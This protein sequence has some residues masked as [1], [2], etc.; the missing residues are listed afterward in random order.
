M[1]D[2]QLKQVYNIHMENSH[3]LVLSVIV[4]YNG[5]EE[6]IE[7]VDSLKVQTYPNI[8]I[9]VVDNA[10]T[11]T[12]VTELRKKH[13]D[14]DIVETG[15]NAG[16]GVGCNVGMAHADSHYIALFNNDLSVHPECIEEMVNAIELDS[17]YGSC[18]SRVLLKDPPDTGEV[19]GIS[20]VADGSSCGRGRLEPAD[21]YLQ[22]EEVFCAN[23]CCA[24][25]KRA[26]MD[27]I[28]NYDPDFFLYCDETDIGIRHQLAGWKCVYNPKAIAYHTHSRAAGSFSDL[29]A[30]YVE[31][32]RILLLLK[33]FP[34][35]GIVWG[36][37]LSFYRYL[38]QILI[39]TKGEGS[40]ARYREEKSLFHGLKIL[41]KAHWNA[42]VLTPKMLKR[43]KKMKPI[44][45]LST[46]EFNALIRKYGISIS[47]MAKYE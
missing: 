45:K 3:P 30:F 26:M 13:P 15:Y 29:K 32:N 34:F 8:R 46:R 43:R 44:F 18:A 1:I 5:G 12:S 47:D 38:Y 42:V 37:I 11:D 21:K 22:L 2:N 39:L 24:L 28:G 7:C 19:C 31:R 35:W 36:T 23:D 16:W 10:S 4:N 9:V 33:Y 14:I 27:E 6:I 40:L 25:Y 41:L 20:I 17:A